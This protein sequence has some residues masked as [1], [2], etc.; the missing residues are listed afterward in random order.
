MVVLSD[1]KDI[2]RELVPG[3]IR[4]AVEIQGMEPNRTENMIESLEYVEKNL[5]R[6]AM[7][8]AGGNKSQAAKI[9]GIPRSTL[10]YKLSKAEDVS[11][12]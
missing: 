12:N 1:G 4:E 5:I 8:K 10:Y 9:L 6:E 3:Y 2:S 11:N 7:A